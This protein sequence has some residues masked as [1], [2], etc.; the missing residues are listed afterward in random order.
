VVCQA[1]VVV[2]AEIQ[3]AALR[4]SDIGALRAQQLAFG[5]VQVSRTDVG[6]LLIEDFLER[7]ISHVTGRAYG[8]QQSGNKQQIGS[9]RS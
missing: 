6:E 3:H 7:G 9:C 8:A 5:L 2:G 1:E 4:D